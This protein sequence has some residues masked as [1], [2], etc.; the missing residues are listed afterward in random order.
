MLI[1]V[2]NYEPQLFGSLRVATLME[3]GIR[4]ISGSLN[5]KNIAMEFRRSCHTIWSYHAAEYIRL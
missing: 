4:D 5:K 2:F 3:M 1:S